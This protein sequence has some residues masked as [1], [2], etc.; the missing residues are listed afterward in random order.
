MAPGATKMLVLIDVQRE[1]NTPG[2]PFCLNGVE[3]PLANCRRL[4][5]HAR[6]HGW[7][8]AHV[9]HQQ[10]GR[11][12]FNPDH[13]YSRFVEGFEPLAHE[14]VFTKGNLSCYSDSACARF[15]E[16]AKNEEVYVAGFNSIMCCLSTVVEAFHRGQRLNFVHDASLARSTPHADEAT[17]H[18][19]ATDI[20]SIYAGVTDTDRVLSQRVAA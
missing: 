20:I 3:T 16:T 17:A 7:V 1:Y 5:E 2:R 4:L 19:H 9:R 10:P 12:L 15:L 11:H 18:L 6:S 8:V 14:K 13:E